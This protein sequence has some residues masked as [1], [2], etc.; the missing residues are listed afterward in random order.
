[1][2]G[3]KI[4]LKYSSKDK[5]QLPVVPEELSLESPFGVNKVNVA[6]KGAITI[7]GLTKGER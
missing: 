7:P 3:I 2:A 4:Y 6:H 5:L 1:M